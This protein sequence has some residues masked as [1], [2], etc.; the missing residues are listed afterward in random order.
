MADQTRN[1]S[2]TVSRGPIPLWSRQGTQAVNAGSDFAKAY[3]ASRV[4]INV[5]KSPYETVL[6]NVKEELKY[7]QAL[8]PGAYESPSDDDYRLVK[9]IA[10]SAIQAYN[11]SAPSNGVDLLVDAPEEEMAS[12]LEKLAKRIADDVLGWGPIAPYM[13]DPMIEEI[14]I[15]G[16]G[17]IFVQ[18]AGE[19]KQPTQARFRTPQQLRNFINNKLD[20]GSGS[21][22]VTARLPYRDHRLSD[23]SR[24]HVIMDP[25]VANLG[26]GGMAVTIR[27]FRSVA[28][29]LDDLL[30]LQTITSA[31]RNF[32][33]AAVQAQL[34]I[35][36]SGGTGTGKTTFLTALTSEID[37]GERV[38][39]VEDTPELQLQHL[40]DWVQLI[41]R[42]KSEGS[43]AV[44]MADLVRHCLRMRPKR[45][46]LG[47]ARG[48][49]MVSILEAM[50][51]GHDGCMFTVHADD[52]FKT[53][54]RIETLYL[55]SNMSNVPL[56]AIRREIASA[57]QIVINIGVFRQP[58]GT[59]IR[60]VKE[61]NYVSGNIEK[62]SPITTEPIFQWK[63]EPGEEEYTGQLEFTGAYPE[64]L[65]KRLETRARWFD[66]ERDIVE[67]SNYE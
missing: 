37:P 15:N 62:E 5:D 64:Q 53:L 16:E 26:I 18:R 4:E 27:R 13:A 9:E 33:A 17:T 34:N 30:R 52:A 32:L 63:R 31:T 61:I 2:G 57:V 42:E 11:N 66:W 29:S 23:G 20:I 59:D 25:L 22:T 43:D 12:E 8:A 65:V 7:G 56:F 48:A 35:C 46:L 24:I 41:T 6:D 14:F 67:A 1:G 39:T 45:V 40:P 58:D 3:R 36:I 49:E 55:K 50:N 38:V 44:V 21:R 51:T 19:T 10:K 54:Q 60:R 28:R 47:E